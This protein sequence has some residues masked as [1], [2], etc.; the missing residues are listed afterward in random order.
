MGRIWQYTPPG[1]RRADGPEILEQEGLPE[2]LVTRTYAQLERI[3]RLIGDTAALMAALRRDPLPVHRVLDIGCGRGGLLAFI[4]HKLGLEGIGVDLRPP[5]RPYSPAVRILA[6]DAV[7]DPL[8]VADVAYALHVTHHL[9]QEEL[10]ALIRNVGRSCRRFLVLDL[11]RHPLP[12]LLFRCF[13]APFVG[14]ISAA[15]GELSVRRAF[16]AE[17]MRAGV[18][19]ALAGTAGTYTQAVAP[20]LVRQLVDIRYVA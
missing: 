12:W 2:E 3:H 10:I 14:A 17:E 18:E 19:T 6:A 4:Q 7:R 16:T 11:I 15:D 9:S 5:R 1:R 8:P 13:V 20:L